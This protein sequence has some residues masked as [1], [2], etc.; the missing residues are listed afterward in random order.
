[1]PKALDLTD[2]T[3]GNLKAIQKAPS[4]NGKTYWTCECL[5]C[6][7]IKLFSLTIKIDFFK[8]HISI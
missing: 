8:N 2:K 6:G 3:F 5:L 4:K 7:N 1:M